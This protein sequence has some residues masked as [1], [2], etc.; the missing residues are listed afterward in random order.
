MQLED[1]RQL[2]VAG[3]S[4][5]AEFKTTTG[6][7]SQGAKTLCGMLNGRGGSV[8]FG[9]TP[10]GELVGQQV[11]DGTLADIS[12]EVTRIDPR[13]F[14]EIDRIE[15]VE[16]RSVIVVRAGRGQNRPYR[17]RGQVYLRVGPTTVEATAEQQ[18]RLLLEQHHGS[19]RWENQ[20]ARGWSVADLDVHE[21]V[22]T[23]EESIRRGRA[24]DPG[25]RDPAE[26]LRGFGLMREG[27]LIRGAVIL[28]GR[29]DRLLPDFP[30]ALL[31]VGRFRGVDRSEFED[32]RRF[33]GHM[34][35]LIRHAERF[36]LENV[37]VASRIVSG[38]LD[39]QD[40]PLYPPAALREALA[41]A[42]CH[43]DYAIGGGSVGIGV[44][45]DRLEIT[46]S[47]PLHFGLRPED[48]YVTHESMPWNPLIANILFRRGFIE[49]W[50]RGTIKIVE[51]SELAGLPRPEIET[52][53][54]AVSVRFRPA[55]YEAPKRVGHD[56]SERRRAI[57]QVLADAR[58][59]RLGEIR[60]A[61]S[62]PVAPA[63]LRDDLRFL[64]GLGLV[65]GEGHGMGASW[66]RELQ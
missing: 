47:G 15:V 35:E 7:R 50:G 1:V 44:Y 54:G 64:R 46:S 52:M 6:Q 58:P 51:L 60:E 16:G 37:P 22:T 66:K 38:R 43:R 27:E 21:V 53:A 8:L 45:D 4:E 33:H 2:V 3:E 23:L 20:T 18:N 36:L 61:L 34:F 12:A 39:R 19:E 28:F 30:Q 63:T 9:V 62:E 24:E 32:N 14:V 17:Y 10:S 29:S 41:N 5:T 49:T 26:I 57:L 55:R 11:T 48:L 40:E 65:S 59:R 25:T 56:L 42:F 31:R 13:P